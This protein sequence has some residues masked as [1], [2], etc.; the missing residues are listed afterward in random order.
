MHNIQI[1]CPE[2][3]TYVINTYRSPSRLFIAG[4]EEILSQEGTTQGDPLAMPWY[5]LCTS[6]MIEYLQ[7][8]TNNVHQVWLAD[9]AAS[10]GR[11]RDLRDWY[12]NLTEVGQYHGYLMNGSKSWLIC[13]S[14]EVAIK[15]TSLQGVSDT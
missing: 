15:G 9:D 1:I 5:S 11:V 13:K 14:E 4:G 6:T 3:A 2:I 10:A 12:N 7:S 8:N